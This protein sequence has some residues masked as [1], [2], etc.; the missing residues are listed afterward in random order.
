MDRTNW[1]FRNTDINILMI[2][3]CYKGVGIP[4]IWKLLTKYGN[5]NANERIKLIDRYIQCFGAD[6]IK[7]F[8][9][10][11][12]FVEEEWF[13]DLIRLKS[14]FYIRLRNNML[15]HKSG[16]EPKPVFWFFKVLPSISVI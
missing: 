11:R 9:A 5:S 1:K 3:V 13:E 16:Q 2:S 8:M 15:V 14:S 4:L 10:D 7:A 12:E 6:S